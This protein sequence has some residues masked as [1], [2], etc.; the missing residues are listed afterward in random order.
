MCLQAVVTRSGLPSSSVIISATQPTKFAFKTMRAKS[1]SS[2]SSCHKV[3]G[4][5]VHRCP[6]PCFEHLSMGRGSQPTDALDHTSCASRALM[7]TLA[8]QP[9]HVC[10][11]QRDWAASIGSHMQQDIDIAK[12]P[13]HLG[14]PIPVSERRSRLKTTIQKIGYNLP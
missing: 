1:S 3:S 8:V 4:S 7:P 14:A 11:R 6:R 5:Y 9:P 13:P 12:A 2:R 10:H